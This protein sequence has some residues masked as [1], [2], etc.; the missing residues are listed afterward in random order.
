MDGN[1]DDMLHGKVLFIDWKDLLM[2]WIQHYAGEKKYYLD[3]GGVWMAHGN[4]NDEKWNG[5]K[6]NKNHF[7]DAILIMLEI[8]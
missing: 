3:L 5:V 6:A 8:K 4:G 2:K 1:E 7:I